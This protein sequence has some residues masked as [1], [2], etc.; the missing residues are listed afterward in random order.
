MMLPP[1]TPRLG[2]L[3][4]STNVA[5][6]PVIHKIPVIVRLPDAPVQVEAWYYAPG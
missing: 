6:K 4:I 3:S 5:V 2:H 1:C